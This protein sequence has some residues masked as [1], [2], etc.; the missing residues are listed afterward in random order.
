[1][2]ISKLAKLKSETILLVKVFEMSGKCEVNTVRVWGCCTRQEYQDQVDRF[3]SE[4]NF[5][6]HNNVPAVQH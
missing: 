2:K 3:H 5:Q 4:Y 6:Y 1:M